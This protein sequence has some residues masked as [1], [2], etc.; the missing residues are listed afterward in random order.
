MGGCVITG[1]KIYCTKCTVQTES[2]ARKW[3]RSL[4]AF[5]TC[6]TSDM[7]CIVNISFLFIHI[8][9][10]GWPLLI[11]TSFFFGSPLKTALL[12]Y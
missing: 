2:L 10:M 3:Q 12:Y 5:T 6:G 7:G 11:K 8:E 1:W 4:T 9:S